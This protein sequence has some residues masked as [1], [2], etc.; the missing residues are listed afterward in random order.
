M[1]AKT[2]WRKQA[3]PSTASITHAMLHEPWFENL[4]LRTTSCRRQN[5]Q[6]FETYF[7]FLYRERV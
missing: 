3:S 2:K 7:F 1:T 4:V 5:E 6:N